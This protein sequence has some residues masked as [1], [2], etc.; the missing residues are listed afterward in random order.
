MNLSTRAL[1]LT[2]DN[3]L[4]PGFVI[5]GTGTK[6][7]LIR[8]VGPGLGDFG[9]EGFME[10]PRLVLKQFVDP[11]W[12]DV[13]TSD[14]WGAADNAA[15]F[16]AVST[17]LGAFPLAPGSRDAAVLA[18]LGPG[19]YTAHVTGSSESAGG[20]IGVALVE[21]YDVG[22]GSG[23]ARLMNLSNRGYVGTG[24]D[25][26]IP[27]FVVSE[28]GPKTFLIRAV[29]PGLWCWALDGLLHDPRLTIY[30]R[31]E[32][33]E[34]PI[35]WCDNWGENGDATQ[36]AQTAAQVGAFEL[37]EG[38]ADAAFVVTLAP[39]VYSVHAAG[40]DGGTGIG[41]VEIYVVE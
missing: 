34:V 19:L 1:G 21:L 2:G 3:L 31:V 15:E 28:E 9:L 32:E 13:Q 23:E 16:D 38:S 41:M 40:K 36:V 7:M 6:R 4:V 8:A 39:G 27:G 12:V 14:D 18:E 33:A 26:M 29:G 17:R 22:E 24:A 30:Q 25:I 10:D 5:E 35:L 11:E 20:G 37:T